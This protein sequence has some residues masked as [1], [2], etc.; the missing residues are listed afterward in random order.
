MLL[1]IHPLNPQARLI[2]QVAGMFKRR[3]HNNLSY[4]YH[5]WPWLRHSSPKSGRK[6]LQNK[7]Y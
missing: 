5:L 1:S 2:K 6:N 7:K 3:W 4:R